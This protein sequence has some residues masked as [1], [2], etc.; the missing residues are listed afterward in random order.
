MALL[1]DDIFRYVGLS[2]DTKQVLAEKDTGS[3]FYET[4]TNQHLVWSGSEWLPYILN[5][6]I[7]FD[8]TP[9]VDSYSR[10]RV[11]NPVVVFDNK[12]VHDRKESLWEEPVIGA[13]IEHGTVTG[14]PFQ[15]G[16][17]ITG[18]TSNKIG[19]VTA[20]DA[21]ALTVTYSVNHNDFQ[22]GET[23]TGSISGASAVVTTHNTGSHVSF[24]RNTACVILQI[25]QNDGDQAIRQT[26]RYFSYIPGK[27]HDIKL[28]FL[29]GT[30]VTNVIRRAG[31]FDD[32]NGIFLQQTDSNIS[33]VIRSK[34]SG[35]V[36]NTVVN[37]A[38]WNLDT[39][40]GNGPSKINYDF[41]KYLFMVID[42]AWQGSDPV[43]C[44]FLY[45][46]HVYYVHEFNFSNTLTVPFMS[47]PSLPVRYE[48]YNDGGTVAA[49]TMKEFCTAVDSSGGERP[50]GLGFSR[51]VDVTGRSV[52]TGALIPVLAIRLKNTHPKGGENRITVEL[53]NVGIFALS[54][55]VHYE[56]QHVH[57]PS[58][59]TATWT[60]QGEGSAVE[61]S[62]DITAI[63]GNPG[64][65]IEEGYVS[66][67]QAG[68]GGEQSVVSIDK[69]DQ[70]RFL[71][72]NYDSTNSEVFC[73][74]AQG[75]GG[76]ATVYP[77]I[78]WVEFD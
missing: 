24:D 59:I 29:F 22:D 3:F 21:G 11:A 67:G 4:D 78:S 53:S 7:R 15:V 68:K 56:L 50:A 58:G 13:I 48:I 23:I 8:N 38:D 36:V 31:Y 42:F 75:I 64:H 30:A 41:S 73:I 5:T 65:D 6:A 33:F 12:N 69:Q 77:H 32:N 47:T 57:D 34:T 35:S 1:E 74:F 10:L 52:G 63:T 54:N 44:G 76:T 46:G 71:T 62:T 16:D 37:Q 25:G 40:D 27:S 49:Q 51:S 28:T 26:H 43:R 72:Q 9:A 55:T 66:A 14:G 60:D 19:T 2:T 61:Y 20:V 17:I 70:H 18:G 39:F 45:R